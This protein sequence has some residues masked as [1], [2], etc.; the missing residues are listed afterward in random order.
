MT[1]ADSRDKVQLSEPLVLAGSE[2]PSDWHAS[3][4]LEKIIDPFCHL[5][6][7]IRP[8]KLVIFQYNR[9]YRTDG[10]ALPWLG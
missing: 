1:S 3:S 9:L 7:Q 2:S 8:D 4:T 6:D 10:K 5:I